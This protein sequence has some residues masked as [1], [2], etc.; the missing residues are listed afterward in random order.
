MGC[1]PSIFLAEVFA[2][3]QCA[4]VN[5]S[6]NQRSDSQVALKPI[7]SY[8][9]KSLSVEECIEKLSRL[10]LCN[11]VHLIWVPVYKGIEGNEKADE[12]G[13][14]AAASKVMG[15]EPH[16]AVGSNTLKELLRTEE[17]VERERQ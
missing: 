3:C 17:R 1:F 2:I 10:S 9:T 14:A 12:L 11:R 15:P 13:R 8:E 5:R 16:I 6:R 4:G 7:S